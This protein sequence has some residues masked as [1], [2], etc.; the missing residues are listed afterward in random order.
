MTDP[1][2]N[3]SWK[4]VAQRQRRQL[5]QLRGEVVVQKRLNLILAERLAI[6]SALLS[7]AAE[8]QTGRQGVVSEQAVQ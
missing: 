1:D 2:A 7:R 4:S 3:T 5:D 6:C 8:R